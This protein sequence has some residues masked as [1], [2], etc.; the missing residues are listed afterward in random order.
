L[1]PHRHPNVFYMTSSKRRRVMKTKQ[2]LMSLLLASAVCAAPAYANYFCNP[3]TSTLLNVGSAMSPTPEDLRIIGD[4]DWV[5]RLSDMNG[6]EVYGKYREYLGYV[7]TVDED[8]R[9]AELQTPTGAAVAVSTAMLVDRGDRV[10][11]PTLS[12]GDVLAM[13][14]PQPYLVAFNEDEDTV[15]TFDDDA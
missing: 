2:I 4:S 11:A 8:N 5:S 12:R 3:Q 1:Q 13:L 7:L 9:L 10:F 15:I 6:K 14:G